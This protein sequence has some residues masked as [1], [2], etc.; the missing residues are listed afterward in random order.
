MSLFSFGDIQFKTAQRTGFGPGNQGLLGGNGYQYNILRYPADL[1]NYGKGHYMVIHI[2]QQRKSQFKTSVASGD[3][4][5]VFDNRINLGIPT[6]GQNVQDITGSLSNLSDTL[7]AA[8]KTNDYGSIANLITSGSSNL[9]SFFKWAQN[10]SGLDVSSDEFKVGFA[11]T[12]ERTTDTIALYMPDTLN[13][14]HNQTY[15]TPSLGGGLGA[16]L[17]TTGSSLVDTLNNVIKSG[18][19]GEA[20]SQ[21]LA[22]VGNLSPFISMAANKYGGSLGQVFFA[23]AS[24]MVQNP[25][26][27]M[28]Y[29]SPSFRSFRF[30]FV[31]Y[32]RD[33]KEALEV[34]KILNRLHFH[35][36]PEISRDSN[37][38]FLIPP[39]EFDIKFYYNGKENP[40]IP[41]ISTC[42][43]E[44]V[45]VDY[46]PNGWSAY[47]T[48]GVNQPTLGGTGMPVAIRLSLGFK[49]TEYLLKDH[50]GGR[51]SGTSRGI[52]NTDSSLDIIPDDWSDPSGGFDSGLSTQADWT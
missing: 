5:T 26:I 37:G 8:A 31:L 14:S 43:L 47:E 41:K 29:S 48:M 16:A 2:N 45:D 7:A 25:M 22:G 15:S 1:G 28:L 24:G 23:A 35:Q 30:D 33:E 34:Q 42:V 21:A 51:T 9:S 36:A 49:E 27:E 32:P 19:T 52:T 10:T 44:T 11:R 17:L 3:L 4:P 12:I 38:F 18:S 6:L 20:V 40:N 50:F 13:F 39:S 46:A